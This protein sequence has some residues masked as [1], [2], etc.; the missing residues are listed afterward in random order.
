ML[1]FFSKLLLVFLPITIFCQSNNNTELFLKYN[2]YQNLYGADC[3][4]DKITNNRGDG[5]EDLYGTRNFRVI[6]HGVA[7]RGG[8]NNYYH[9][10]NKRSNKNPLPMD[11]LNN[12]LN[13]GFSTS[14]Y[15]YNVNFESS[16]K[17]LVNNKSNDTLKYF[18]LGG[19]NSSELDSILMFTYN[20][21]M[22]HD[23]GP[24]Y[25]HCWNGWHQSGFVSAVLLKQF[26][27]Y[28]TEKALRYWEDCADNWTRG[29][30]R[31]RNAIRDF[32]P[33]QKYAIPEDISNE[34][35]PCYTDER[36]NDKMIIQNNN[37]ELKSLKITVQFPSNVS[38]LPPSVSTFL[39]EYA[40]MLIENSYLEIEVAGHTDTKGSK[41]YNLT[42]SKTRAKN[43]MDYLILQGV[44]PSKLTY[45]GYGEEFP[46]NEC[47]DNVWCNDEK[48]AKNRRI[49]FNINN[50]S[51]QVNFQKNS[52]VI[53]HKDKLVLSNILL[54]LKSEENLKVEIGGHADKGTGDDFI[55][56]NISTLRAQ[57][58]F[59]YLKTNGLDMTNITYVGYG[60]R[61][62]K[63]GDERDRR[64]EFKILKDE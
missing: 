38:D 3:V 42:L 19:N 23:V 1:K 56:D 4:E 33:L 43:V 60:S 27:G 50:I 48:H 47:V 40:A 46:I 53:S 58:V 18:Q 61:L 64:I 15:L 25:L 49:D 14:V 7:Y 9:R 44:D 5:F 24:V 63:F 62:E 51:Y 6:L 11:G 2:K 54:I 22:N 57:K 16:P 36:E 28:S 35:C 8:G 41:E 13:N 39:D 37:D 55:N 17:Y 45:K 12:L 21:I 59:N 31:I 26:C 29:Y 32:D 52:S 30:D 20:S 10:S 34:I